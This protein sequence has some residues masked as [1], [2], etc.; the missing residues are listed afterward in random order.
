MT[1]MSIQCKC[2]F[3][4]LVEIEFDTNGCFPT[5]NL[6]P[7]I[8]ST[9]CVEMTLEDDETGEGAIFVKNCLLA[10]ALYAKNNRGLTK[11]NSCLHLDGEGYEC[12][13]IHTEKKNIFTVHFKTLTHTDEDPCN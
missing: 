12:R 10:I 11:P 7:K 3:C 13:V 1:K 9:H 4:P 6:R 5:I 2:P 8:V